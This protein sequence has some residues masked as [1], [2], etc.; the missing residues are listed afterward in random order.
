MAL[1]RHQSS[2]ERVLDFSTTFSLNSQQRQRATTLLRSL[3]QL[4][5]VEQTIRHGFK[6]ASLIQFT[7]EHIKGQDAFLSFYFSFL[8]ENLC[9]SL[10]DSTEPEIAVA[11]SF[12]DDFSTWDQNKKK[13]ANGASEKFAEY[14]VENFLLPLRASSVKTPQPTPSSLSSIQPSTPT[15]T[16]QRISILRQNCLV[17]DHHRC[18]VSRKFDISEARR[19]WQQDGDD[20]KDDDGNLLRNE[21]S[22]FQYLEVAHILPHCLTTVASRD[23]DL[24]DSKKN[25]LRILNMFDPGIIHL[26]DGPKIDSPLN[27]L[28]LTHDHHR[29]FGEFRIYF[30]PTST[31][32]QYKI[33]SMEQ[34][35]FIR[36][37]LFPVTRTLTL[38][39]NRTI[40]PPSTRLLNVHRAIAR[41]MNLSGAGEYIEKILRDLEEVDVRADGSTNLGRVM[42][43]RLGGWLN[44]P[45]VD[46]F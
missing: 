5:G 8:Y 10:T 20:F 33:D 15:G 28:T 25:V 6:P 38:S 44:P 31:Q 23:T 39:P 46:V 17:R 3:V 7:F 12:F 24:S 42:N 36:D 37:P 30:E 41:I 35:P 32:D 40:D 43:L 19:R 29:A 11:L 21:Q 1:H 45:T 18:I 27:A 26:I 13:D 4:Y 9:P 22:N 16:T 34:S 2:L 14:I